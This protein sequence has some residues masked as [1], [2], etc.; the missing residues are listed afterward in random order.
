MDIGTDVPEI[1]ISQI[2]YQEKK[3]NNLPELNHTSSTVCI[4]QILINFKFHRNCWWSHILCTIEAK[5]IC[6]LYWKSCM[7]SSRC[8]WCMTSRWNLRS[9]CGIYIMPN[10]AKFCLVEYIV[11]LKLKQTAFKKVFFPSS[12][13]ATD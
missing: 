13:S 10:L 7:A 9:R 5:N 11:K 6:R 3:L 8:S 4:T 12:N 1:H 2:S